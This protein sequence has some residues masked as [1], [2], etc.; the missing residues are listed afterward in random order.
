MDTSFDAFNY[1]TSDSLPQE[2]APA[3]D[4]RYQRPMRTK[5]IT[6][7]PKDIWICG[8][9]DKTAKRLTELEALGD[10]SGVV[11][12]KMIDPDNIN[13]QIAEV[14]QKMVDIL[15]G[16]VQL[17]IG[18]NRGHKKCHFKLACE[19]GIDGD[20]GFSHPTANWIVW[21]LFRRVY[22]STKRSQSQPTG[23]AANA[24]DDNPFDVY[25]D[26]QS[27]KGF[28]RHQ[29]PESLPFTVD[30][31][32]RMNTADDKLAKMFTNTLIDFFAGRRSLPRI[33]SI[34]A[35][36]ERPARWCKGPFCYRTLMASNSKDA[37]T[38]CKSFHSDEVSFLTSLARV[39][40][41]AHKIALVAEPEAASSSSARAPRPAYV[42]RAPV[43]APAVKKASS[44]GNNT[45]AALL[46]GNEDE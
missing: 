37:N 16:H 38:S 17:P 4:R 25:D 20:H 5:V 21:E 18:D 12:M 45:F 3:A 7:L 32:P 30:V 6:S 41:E 46:E 34:T 33:G 9:K 19:K 11:D 15:R 26:T 22:C 24:D 39:L 13:G 14:K 35:S 43:Y 1:E 36:K 40:V 28:Y 23:S 31:V 10:N 42:R 8:S 29:H 27:E 44:T 2:I